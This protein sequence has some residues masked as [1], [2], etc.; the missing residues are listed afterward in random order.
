MKRFLIV[1][2]GLCALVAATSIRILEERYIA[3]RTLLGDPE[4]AW[5][6]WMESQLVGP[7]LYLHLPF[8]H[9]VDVLDRRIQR[10][11]S[12][13]R[14]LYLEQ[15][16]VSIGYFVVWR[17]EDIR[18][19]FENTQPSEMLKLIDD[20]TYNAVRNE[21]AT[22]SL[23]DLLSG[24]RE[25]IAERIQEK[26]DQ[27]LDKIGIEVLG[28]TIRQV[29]F[30]ATTLQRVFDRMKQDRERLAKKLRAEGEEQA[31][32]IRAGADRDAEI[33]L[34]RA[35]GEA[36]R[37]QGEGDARAAAIYAEAFDQDR[38]FYR[39]VRSLEAYRK[40]L[41]EKTTLVLSPDDPFLR[42]LFQEGE[43]PSGSSAPAAP[44]NAVPL[45]TTP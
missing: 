32:E 29:E 36:A 19:L 28:V 38:E 18:L 2:L 45:P 25:E 13:S 12:D 42:Y 41:D 8:L 21:L 35:R 11:E 34:A 4:P 14:E 43:A 16:N 26:S 44:A 24:T 31:R 22:R 37:L 1:V 17:I 10:F 7:S 23:G 33:E 27:E 15:D 39:F 20:K 3:F 30:L 6:P 9:Q 5:F 40:S